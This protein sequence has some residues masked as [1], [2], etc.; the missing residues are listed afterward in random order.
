MPGPEETAHA[1]CSKVV[2][3]SRSLDRDIAIDMPRAFRRQCAADAGA[4]AAH[5]AS[6]K[7]LRAFCGAGGRCWPQVR[8]ALLLT[9]V[10]TPGKL[11][12]DRG[13]LVRWPLLLA[14]VLV[15]GAAA[16]VV[17]LHRPAPPSST[18]VTAPVGSAVAG[19]AGLTDDEVFQASMA[20]LAEAQRRAEAE[21]A[22]VDAGTARTGVVPDA[23]G[24]LAVLLA[25][26]DGGVAVP[27]RAELERVA[28]LL[29]D[30]DYAGAVERVHG[31]FRESSPTAM[32]ALELVVTTAQ[33]HAR[34]GGLHDV[35]PI[36]GRVQELPTSEPRVRTAVARLLGTVAL[37]SVRA[38]NTERS[39][40]QAQAALALAETT[41]EAYLALG[42][43]EFQD[44][45][46][47]SALLTWE[48][49]LR[50]N[51]NNVALARRLERG[52]E[53]SQRL[54]GLE[55]V[56]SEHFVV[57]FDGRADVPAARA[58]LEVM[59]DAYRAVGGLFDL[60]PDPPIP[61]VLY[62]ERTFDQ[63]GHASWTAAVYD[64]KIRLPSAGADLHSLKFR[65]TLFHE[66]AHALFHRA[67]GARQAA[68]SWLNEGFAEIAR[69]RADSGPPVRCMQDAHSFP[70]R[71]LEG[72]FQG[73]NRRSAGFAYLEGRHAVERIIERHGEQGVRAIL[74]ELSKGA[75][76]PVAFQSALGEEYATFAA[77]F[78][79]EASR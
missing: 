34:A 53:E 31:L 44:N 54:G 7:T 26:A 77:R 18:P 15:V 62:P 58:S 68:P 43:D 3:R 40:H 49:G 6:A 52:L 36:V 38:G 11:G 23:G 66:Y 45:D 55:R 33:E 25:F 41:P 69:R 76:F 65:G 79:A 42:E 56:S 20:R 47:P 2:Q 73:L 50:L 75:P 14:P 60:Y 46:L 48:R 24:A 28:A 63:E 39:R 1:L 22:S 8:G 32:P 51:P 59:E 72:N 4:I 13:V 16:A 30:G 19:D 37:A 27:R 35:E 12:Q 9:P 71:N 64:G 61:V 5:P 74:A 78:D 17:V 70:L 57:A 21:A 67:S 29:F 10:R